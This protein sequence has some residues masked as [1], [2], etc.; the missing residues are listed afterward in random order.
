M[1]VPDLAAKAPV[2]KPKPTS[3]SVPENYES[4]ITVVP[5]MTLT[6]TRM[7]VL[8][9]EPRTPTAT[10]MTYSLGGTDAASFDIV[11]AD[12]QITVK[13]ATKLDL[14]A[15]ATYMVTVTATDPGGLSDSVDVT[16]MVTNVDEAPMIERGGLAISGMSSISYA[17]NG[18]DAVAEYTLAGP[19]KDNARWSLEGDDASDFTL[20][21]GTLKFKRSPNYEMHMDSDTDNVYMVTVKAMDGTY[22][23]MKPVTVTVTNVDEIGTLSG[24]GTVSNY[25]EDSEDAVG[26]YTVSGGSMSE[27]ANLTLMGD[28]AGDFRI[29]DDGMLTF[30]SSPDFENP[31]DSDTDN[32]YMVTVKAEAGGEMAMRPVTV[33]VTNEEEPG[34][35]TLWDGTVAL[36]MAPQVGDIITGAVMDPDGGE[37]VES[38]QWSRTMTPNMMDSWMDIAGETNA[39]YMVMEGDTGYYLR[40][41][42]TYTDAAG[43]DMAME[44]SMPTMMVMMVTSNN[45]PVFQDAQSMDITETTR[46][47]AENTAAGELGAPVM[48]MDADNDTLTYSLGGTDM[49]SFGIDMATGQLMTQDAL[50]YE[51]KDS[52]E[53]TVT[54]TDPAGASDMITVTI[55]VINV[56]EPG[57][58]TLSDGTDALTMAP[59]VGDTITGAVM[60]PDGGVTGETWQWS[61]T[62][63]PDMMDTCDGHHRR[64]RRRLH[65]G[66]GRCWILPAGNGDVRRLGGHDHEGLGTDHDGDHE[67]LPHVQLRGRHK[68]SR[69][70]HGGGHGHRRPGDGHGR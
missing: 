38:W 25:M 17:E 49:A 44:Y 24:P 45:A 57:E 53:V 35:V 60:D 1:V 26:T 59:Q 64:D 7:W 67:R 10:P 16:I 13:T 52:Y 28:D 31:M 2:F 11:Q 61:T 12:G 56:E 37:T 66:R 23:A 51:T 14:E 29:M 21:N 63:M 62:M 32:E 4:G 65:G 22:T 5:T 41:M 42:A 33:T 39:A 70:E 9:S 15:K 27:M 19:M 55:T 8:W 46:M 69:G 40:V 54:A 68:R 34:R 50:D 58:V 43:A 20:M 48:A 18:T 30:R 6:L 47:V 36:T 3:R